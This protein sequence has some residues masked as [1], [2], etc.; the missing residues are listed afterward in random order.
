MHSYLC[1]LVFVF[2]CIL[3]KIW[4]PV[5]ACTSILYTFKYSALSYV[6][7]CSCLRYTCA[8]KLSYSESKKFVPP[9]VWI[10]PYTILANKNLYR[11]TCSVE[12]KAYNEN[13][14][15][16]LNWSPVSVILRVFYR[17][18]ALHFVFFETNSVLENIECD[19]FKNISTLVFLDLLLIDYW[20]TCVFEYQAAYLLYIPCVI[21]FRFYNSELFPGTF[22]F[23][24]VVST[25]ARTLTSIFWDAQKPQQ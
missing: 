1:A 4:G 3:G 15:N 21:E 23:L 5:Y 2:A 16:A 8:I 18:A 13:F 11:G 14:F 17:I 6:Y 7:T 22:S 20:G 10:N 12:Q 25:Q 24:F 9:C 19:Q